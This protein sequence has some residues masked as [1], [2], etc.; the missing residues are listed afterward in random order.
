MLTRSPFQS[1]VIRRWSSVEATDD[2]EPVGVGAD[3]LTLDGQDAATQLADQV[4]GALVGQAQR[5]APARRRLYRIDRPG[6]AVLIAA[7]QHDGRGD[8]PDTPCMMILSWQGKT[9]GAVP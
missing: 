4:R 9:V 2:L 3:D 1:D 8:R 6:I 7:R 5:D